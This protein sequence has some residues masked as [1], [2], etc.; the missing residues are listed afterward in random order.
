[1]TCAPADLVCSIEELGETLTS[2]NINDFFTT[3]LA[4]LV[5]VVVG[6]LLTTIIGRVEA[7]NR[8]ILRDE[9]AAK[10]KTLRD[11]EAKERREAREAEAAHQRR[12]RD[13]EAQ[14]RREAR[15]ADA[16]QQRIVRLEDALARLIW[17]INQ[18]ALNLRAL[19]ERQQVEDPAPE[20][21]PQD[22]PV[23]AAIAAAR[24]IARQG[25][26]SAVL[27]AIR[28]L[29]LG[30]RMTDIKQRTNSLTMVWRALIIWR[31]GRPVA[32]VLSDIASLRVSG[33]D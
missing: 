21:G 1:M 9:E 22:W 29:V 25:D 6:A 5:G 28:E 33:G 15:E 23:L 31:E 10:Q 17:E 30:V 12:L 32:E 26:E 18:H 7:K 14:E 2:F 3:A 20:W 19:W 24:M 13:E 4:T 8:R 27:D 16:E 11:E